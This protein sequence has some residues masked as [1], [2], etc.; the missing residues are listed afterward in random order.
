MPDWKAVPVTGPNDPPDAA[1]LAEI[2]TRFQAFADQVVR[3]LPL[4]RRICQAAATDP[5]VCARLLLP[6]PT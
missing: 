6:P 4:Y 2:A 3:R 1:E 5:E